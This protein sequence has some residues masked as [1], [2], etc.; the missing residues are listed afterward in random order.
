[1]ELKNTA[2]FSELREAYTS[3]NSQTDQV[4]E[5]ISEIEDKL[6]K[7]KQESKI[8]EKTV[9]GNE[10]SLQEIWDYVKRPNL[11]LIGISECDGENENKLENYSSGY[12]PGKLPQPSKAGQYS[13]PENTENT[14]KIFCKKSNHKAHNRQI[15][16]G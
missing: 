3:F 9:K 5:R 1:M 15:H 4:E 6:K 8:K 11:R 13:S 2:C 10:Q 12:Y 7:I 16:Q 14:T